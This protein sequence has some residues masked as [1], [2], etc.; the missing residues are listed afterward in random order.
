MVFDYKKRND[1]FVEPVREGNVFNLLSSGYFRIDPY[2][3]KVVDFGISFEMP[4][5][6]IANLCPHPELFLAK[7]VY[8]LKDFFKNGENINGVFMNVCLPDFLY[9]K[10]K[11]VLANSVFFGSHNTL[12]F[13]KGDVVAKLFF[14]RIEKVAQNVK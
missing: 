4:E 3:R 7:G 2:E 14:S 11:S 5:D 6:V 13:D 12:V 9:I 1:S 10:E 8:V